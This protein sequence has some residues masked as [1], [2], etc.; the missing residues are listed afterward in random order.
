MSS[1]I[2]EDQWV[3]VVV[4]DPEGEALLLGQ[5]DEEKGERFVPAFLE[6]EHALAAL[7]RLAREPGLRHEVQAIPFQ[8][9]AAQVKRDTCCVFVLDASGRVLERIHP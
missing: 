7:N 1:P 3:W 8:D 2:A 9:L 4:R 5:V 6:K